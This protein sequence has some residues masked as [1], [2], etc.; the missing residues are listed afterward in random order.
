LQGSTPVALEGTLETPPVKAPVKH[1]TAKSVTLKPSSI[2]LT[3]DGNISLTAKDDPKDA[4]A[5][6]LME[7]AKQQKAAAALRK[8]STGSSSSGSNGIP[9]GGSSGIARTGST[10]STGIARTGSTGSTGSAKKTPVTTPRTTLVAPPDKV[11]AAN[12]A[13]ASAAKVLTGKKRGRSP[14]A[15]GVNTRNTRGAAKRA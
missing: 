4:Y 1:G 6:E 2:S 10:S 7:L 12:A 14:A 13:A 3:P 11:R 15:V 9:R 8:A 5:K